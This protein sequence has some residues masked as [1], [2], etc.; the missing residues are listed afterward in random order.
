LYVFRIYDNSLAARQRE[1]SANEFFAVYKSLIIKD[2]QFL[3][4]ED[5]FESETGSTVAPV[6][7]SFTGRK[8]AGI[9]RR[10][11]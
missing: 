5:R 6:H 10:P 2:L 9:F 3:T 8:G 4:V 11:G 1:G 7:Q